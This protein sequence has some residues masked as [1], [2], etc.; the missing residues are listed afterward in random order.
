MGGYG[1]YVF[2]AYSSVMLFLLIQWFLPWRAWR[3]YVR[4]QNKKYE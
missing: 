3:R 1:K 2:S 4:A